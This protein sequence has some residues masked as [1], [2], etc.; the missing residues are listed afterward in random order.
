MAK[1]NG[2]EMKTFKTF[3]GH[4]GNAAQATIYVDGKKAGFWSQ[5][6]WGG[7]DS[8]DKGLEEIVSERAKAFQKGCPENAK[9][10]SVL[11]DADVFMGTLLR[12]CEDE[13]QYKKYQ[14][15][16]YPCMVTISNGFRCVYTAFKKPITMKW[17]ENGGAFLSA[18]TKEMMYKNGDPTIYISNSLDDF[19]ITVDENHPCPEWLL[20]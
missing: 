20:K 18:E 6:S 13:K 12:I 9:F 10:Y 2:V 3:V 5:D 8:Y 16:G 7:C 17:I 1:L 4:D 14:K 15:Q 11:D 19:D